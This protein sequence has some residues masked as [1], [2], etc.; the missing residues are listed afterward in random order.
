MYL[1]QLCLN[2]MDRS[3][4]RALSDA[5]QLHQTVMKGFVSYKDV[6][7]VLFRVEPEIT[8]GLALI[9]V[10]S[11]VEPDWDMLTN[12]NRWVTATKV[13]EFVAKFRVGYSLRFRLRANPVVT[14]EGKR[15]GLIRDE[16]LLEW[17]SKKEQ[18][19]GARFKSMTVIDEGYITGN[20]QNKNSQHRLNLKIA[21]FEGMLEVIDPVAFSE[22]V[23]V[24]IGPAKAFGCGLLSLAKA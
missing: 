14:R 8:N 17:L 24:G 4:M 10:Q 15:Y 18:K 23:E 1:T 22:T 5:Y 12:D 3:V 11:T 2:R 13:K 7:R 6:A 20:K 21:R 9:L 19:L 16:S